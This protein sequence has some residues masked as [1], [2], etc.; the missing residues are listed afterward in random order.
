MVG[1]IFHQILTLL[2]RKVYIQNTFVISRSSCLWIVCGKC[3]TCPGQGA[4]RLNF[5]GIDAPGPA[6]TFE[7]TLALT[8]RKKYFEDPRME[9]RLLNTILEEDAGIIIVTSGKFFVL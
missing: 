3:C 8:S 9:L 1:Y 5:G 4:P 2:L 7:D 6:H